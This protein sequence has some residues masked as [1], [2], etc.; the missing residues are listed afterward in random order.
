MYEFLQDAAFREARK[1]KRYW[2][3]RK[4]LQET[5]GWDDVFRNLEKSIEEQ[6]L[7]K[8][9][10]YFSLVTHNGHLH[11]PQATAFL[12][13]VQQFDP[14]LAGSAHVYIGLTKFSESFGRHRDN[15]D[16]FFWQV[17][18][19]TNWKVYPDDG[20]K[21]HVLTAGDIIYIPRYMDHEVTSLCPRVGISFGLDYGEKK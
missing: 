2:F 21:E 19:S 8:I 16:V 20:V 15:S 7:V 13:E 18:G 3:F 9:G 17:I 4:A 1:A 11:I 6:S 5:P 12:K 10:P 14:S